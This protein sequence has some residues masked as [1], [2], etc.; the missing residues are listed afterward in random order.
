MSG[1]ADHGRSAVRL[2]P[3]DAIGDLSTMKIRV[4]LAV[5]T[6]LGLLI[7]GGS[8]FQASAQIGIV[9]PNP[10]GADGAYNTFNTGGLQQ[11]RLPP[12][13]IW[14]EIISVNNPWIV[15]QNQAGQEFPIAADQIRQF[16][17][18]WPST[19]NALTNRSVIEVTGPEA[20]SNVVI[21][22]HL[23]VYEGADQSLVSP[24]VNNLYGFNR[25]LSA[26]D[27]D[28]QNTYGV[29]YWMT[30]EEYAIPS[31]MHLVGNSIVD[32][33]GV[34]KVT[35]FGQNWYT[36]Q[37]SAN[38]MSVTQVTQGSITY[39]KPGDLIYFIPAGLTPKSLSVAQLVLYKKIPIGQFQ[40]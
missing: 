10:Y 29:V 25:T 31:R 22:D 33:S 16:L 38:G 7:A 1:K 23:D 20:G 17:I 27:T 14:A 18:R 21:A 26:F 24:A 13:G 40:P 34:V 19:T 32:G 9:T 39:A 15:I 37:P 3:L 2:G 36:I 11:T 8:V 35:G 12:Q 4:R 5:A 30:P 6:A 28:Q